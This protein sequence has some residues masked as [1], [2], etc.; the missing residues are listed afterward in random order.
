MSDPQTAGGL[1]ATGH[2][3]QA[4]ACVAELKRLGYEHSAIIG[5][6]KPESDAIEPIRFMDGFPGEISGAL[7]AE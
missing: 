7:A 3:D 5:V 6:V 2:G 4:A 1:L